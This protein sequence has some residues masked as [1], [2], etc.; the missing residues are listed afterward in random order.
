MRQYTPRRVE[1]FLRARRGEI[2]RRIMRSVKYDHRPTSS[3]KFFSQLKDEGWTYTCGAINA[4]NSTL[5]TTPFVSIG[6]LYSRGIESRYCAM[7]SL[8]CRNC[9]SACIESVVKVEAVKISGGK[10]GKVVVKAESGEETDDNVA[11]P[12][13]DK[14]L[15][16]DCGHCSD[17]SNGSR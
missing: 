2:I 15:A 14:F 13:G 7:R 9:G 4:I 11:Y 3:H 1:H 6:F 10:S 8:R 12:G 16:G 17:G 5:S